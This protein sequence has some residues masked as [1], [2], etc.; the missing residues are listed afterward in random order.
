MN[1]V[2]QVALEKAVRLLDSLNLLYDMRIV[3]TE[4]R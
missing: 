3:Y 2:Q 4:V 1:G